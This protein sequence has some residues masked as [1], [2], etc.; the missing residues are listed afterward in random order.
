MGLPQLLVTGLD[1][2]Q[3]GTNGNLLFTAVVIF[4]VLF[5]FELAV[6][7]LLGILFAYD[8]KLSSPEARKGLSR[9]LNE[10]M[11]MMLMAVMGYVAYVEMGR[12]S[13]FTSGVGLDNVIRHMEIFLDMHMCVYLIICVQIL[14]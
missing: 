8:I 6:N 14:L 13:A 12:F 3:F 4:F 7:V 2:E 9:G 11:A 10:V 1:Y 5:A